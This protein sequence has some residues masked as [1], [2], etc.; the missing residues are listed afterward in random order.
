MMHRRDFITLLGSP[1]AAR[2]LAAQQKTVP[3]IGY[4]GNYGT[5][6]VPD[7]RNE[8]SLAAFRQGLMETGCTEDRNVRGPS[9]AASN[10]GG[11]RGSG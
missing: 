1:A 10:A 2:P 9:D 4:L 6:A 11:T 8:R 7:P 3:V 5:G